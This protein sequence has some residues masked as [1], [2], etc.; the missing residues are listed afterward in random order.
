MGVE[1][2]AAIGIPAAIAL[3]SELTSDK[4]GADAGVSA[5]N[6][7]KLRLMKQAQDQLGQYRP[8][9]ANAEMGAMKDVQSS[10]Q[11]ANDAL[12]TM[13]GGGR[14]TAPGGPGSS[15]GMLPDPSV[16]GST[17]DNTS[18]R[19]MSG[20]GANIQGPPK[21]AFSPPGG[22]LGTGP[23]PMG[24]I[25][26]AASGVSPFGGVLGKGPPMGTPTRGLPDPMQILG[27]K[28]VNR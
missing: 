22:P 6:A 3:F 5:A 16:L 13:Y 21:Q 26:D 18:L 7:D 2:I 27:G 28:K 9:L 17:K 14:K 8:Q 19:Q 1:T 25:A 15:M 12:A 24:S 4:G 10:Y 20:G 23:K 11:G